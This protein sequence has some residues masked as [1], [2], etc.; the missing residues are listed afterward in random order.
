MNI[1]QAVVL[2]PAVHAKQ[3]EREGRR[4]PD[5]PAAPGHHQ[6]E[7]GDGD[8]EAGRRQSRSGQIYGQSSTTYDVHQ[9]SNQIQPNPNKTNQK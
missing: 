6:R 8:L 7:A 1:L 2:P 4:A 5:R 3:E 9:P